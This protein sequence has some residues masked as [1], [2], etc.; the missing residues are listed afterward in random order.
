MS[1]GLARSIDWI[2]GMDLFLILSHW[3]HSHQRPQMHGSWALAIAAAQAMLIH[4]WCW[5]VI[6]MSLSEPHASVTSLCPCVCMFACLLGLTTYRNFKSADFAMQVHVHY[7]K[8]FVHSA[9][10]YFRIL[11]Y[12]FASCINELRNSIGVTSH[13]VALLQPCKVL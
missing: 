2:S 6:G 3:L 10:S 5:M 13:P 7:F 12:A 4:V 8:I 9:V 11:F 1:I